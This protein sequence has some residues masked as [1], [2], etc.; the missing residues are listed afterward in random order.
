MN[1]PLTLRESR[2]PTYETRLR[3][4]EELRVARQE[5]LFGLGASL[6]LM[7]MASFGL[8]ALTEGAVIQGLL[9]VLVIFYAFRVR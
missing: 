6:V 5:I 7:V 1:G 2:G 9:D 8:I 3:R 4:W